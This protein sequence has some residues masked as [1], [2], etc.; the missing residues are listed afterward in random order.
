MKR[1]AARTTGM[2]A[3]SILI[4]VFAVAPVD[5]V[6][7]EQD[8]VPVDQPEWCVLRRGAGRGAGRVGER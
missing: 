2:L 1:P 8:P 5:S 7:P 6:R 4:A 3:V